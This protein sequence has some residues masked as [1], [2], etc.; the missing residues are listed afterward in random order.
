MTALIRK[1]WDEKPL[2]VIMALGILFRLLSV[3]FAK[4]WGMIDDH[5][6]VIESA[7]SW[8]D[9][10]DYNAWLPGSP[11][12]TGPTGHNFFYPGL[13][14]LAFSFF[15]L[16]HLD[17]PQLK[18]LIIR[19]L[20][21]S[22][23]LLTIYFGY[24]ITERLSDKHSAR[25]VGLLL[26]IFWFMPWMSVRDLVEM[27][28]VPFLVIAVWFI[29]SRGDH[30][31]QTAAYFLGG[32]FLG[33]AFN[34]RPQT[35]FFSAGLVLAVLIE[36]KW[37]ESITLFLGILLPYV[38]IQ[39]SIDFFIWGKPFV[40]LAEYV[41][42]NFR[43]AGDYITLPWYNYFLVV[44]GFLV[45]PVS[46]MLFFGFLRNWKRLFIIF[47]P[48]ALF[49]AAHSYFPNKQERFILPI[50]PFIVISGV[51][52]WNEFIDRSKFWQ[53]RKGLLKGCW[54]F[55]WII[56]V[57]LL[58]FASTVYSKRARV[59]TMTYLSKYPDLKYL[60]VADSDNNPE[61][62]PEFYLGQWPGIY[63]ELQGN[64]T[65]PDLIGRVSGQP[66]REH[67]RFILFT[68][69]ELKPETIIQARKSFPFL[70]YETTI[71]PGTVDKLVHWLNPINVS[72]K[73]FIYRNKVFFPEKKTD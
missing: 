72:R 50:L 71:E 26:A 56:N 18:M 65:T 55:F 10:Y 29:I 16:I 31:G 14:F 11:H 30:P 13:H 52:G 4:G 60:M 45:P 44:L 58:C 3:I 57:G 68:G 41:K 61:L 21:A 19:F 54:I 46:L 66:Q 47:I 2:L 73:C 8:V 39:G 67:P 36:R 28:S 64:E 37:K 62:F 34:I 22:W 23:S 59:E 43:S 24:K 51:I 49:F 25:L 1:Y 48:V 53:N 40:E 35:L 42:V 33:L 15:K 32:L 63:E 20:N 6:I 12:N 5:F 70:V 17:D 38:L 27:S 69:S 9:G 7:Q